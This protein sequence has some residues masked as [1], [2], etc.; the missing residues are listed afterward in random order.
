[1][2]RVWKLQYIQQTFNRPQN[3]FQPAMYVQNY[4]FLVTQTWTSKNNVFIKTISSF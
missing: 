3:L 2:A 1:M 4:S